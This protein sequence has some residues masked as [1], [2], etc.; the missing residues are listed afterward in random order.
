[1]SY[2]A[3]SSKL[4]KIAI[5]ASKRNVFFTLSDPRN[6]V[7]KLVTPGLILKTSVN[8]KD[9]LRLD[10]RKNRRKKRS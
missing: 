1:M 8:R 10:D 9:Y 7:K 6:K 2:F 5:S 4:W 3:V